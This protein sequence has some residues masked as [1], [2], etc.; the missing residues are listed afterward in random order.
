MQQHEPVNKDGKFKTFLRTK[1][2]EFIV[3]F[4]LSMTLVVISFGMTTSHDTYVRAE[5]KKTEAQHTFMDYADNQ[6]AKMLENIQIIF[7]QHQQQEQL[8]LQSMEKKI[9]RMD[10]KLDNWMLNQKGGH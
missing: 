1:E 10:G 5:D 3:S 2:G 9:D 8:F 6:D 7:Q 4:I